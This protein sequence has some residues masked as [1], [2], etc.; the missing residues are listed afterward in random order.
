VSSFYEIPNLLE[1]FQSSLVQDYVDII[2]FVESPKY[3]GRKLYPR[4][5][6]LLKILFLQEL[7]DYDKRVLKEWEESDEVEICPKLDERI[8]YLRKNG[9]SHFRTIQLVGGRRSSKGFLTACCI[10]YKLYLMAQIED[11]SEQFNIPEGKEVYF[12]IVAN[13]LD[14]AIAHQFSDASDAV[15]STK[16]LHSRKLV[17]KVL[18]QSISV[19]TPGDLRRAAM[20]RASGVQV[21]KDMASLVVKA[22]GTNSNTIRGSASIM[23][24]FDEMAHLVAGDSRMSDDE[25]WT[26]AVPSVNQF[27]EQGMIFANSSP[28]QKTGRFYELYEQA[29]QLEKIKEENEEGIEVE[30][31]GPPAFPDHFLLQYPSWALYEDW[32]E[33]DMPPPQV[34]RPEDDPIVASEE[35]RDPDTFKVEYRAQFAEVIDSF[36][37]PEL[38]DQMFDPEFNDRVLGKELRPTSGAVSFV[39]YKGHGD[40][41]SVGPANFGIAVGHIET[42]ENQDTGLHEQHVVFDLIDAFYPEDFKNHTIDWTEIV[43][44]ITRL[45]NAFRPFEWTFDQFD[46]TMAIQTLQNNLSQLGVRDTMVYVKTATWEG[47]MRRAKNFRAALNLGRVHAPH[48]D[49][50]NALAT[51]N[52]IELARQ[53]LKFLQ[54]KNGRV[55]RQKIGPVRTKDIADCIMEVTDALIGDTITPHAT[56]VSSEFALGA[57]GGFRLGAGNTE[58]FAELAEWHRVSGAD[59]SKGGDVWVPGRRTRR[60]K[61]PY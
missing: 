45:I 34:M 23:F 1:Q 41:S 43:P 57:K 39:T 25:L 48:P 53:E 7:D 13:S 51:K 16:P 8:D 31:F 42:I 6:T 26:A 2:E 50:Y 58:Q 24:I 47:N 49:T 14:Q 59:R 54:E 61:R 55:D 27:R 20:Y 15:L 36:L 35:R 4:Q 32:D 9:Y 60:D 5:R 22:N 28:Y 52:S 11:L 18:A 40:P 56:G 10:A 17:G 3:L 19:N 30:K 38:V 37:R 29:F 46:S 33:F 21:N 44:E 12:N